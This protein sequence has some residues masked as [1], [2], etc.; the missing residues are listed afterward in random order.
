MTPFDSR[1]AD[2]SDDPRG[3]GG[4]L[5]SAS[6]AAARK[7]A[8]EQQVLGRVAVDRQLGED[9]EPG[10]LAAGARDPSAVAPGVALDV[11]DG[12]VHLRERDPQR[13]GALLACHGSSMAADAAP[14]RASGAAAA[15]PGPMLE[16]IRATTVT[17]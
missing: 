4:E 14:T 5:A 6:R 10:A 16:T 11:A 12:R 17:R 13:R 1:E 7:C 8:L 9:D 2:Q 15:P 3:L